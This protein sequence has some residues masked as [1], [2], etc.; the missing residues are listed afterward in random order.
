MRLPTNLQRS[1]A[2]LAT[3]FH[4]LEC[5]SNLVIRIN[6]SQATIWLDDWVRTY[7][8]LTTKLGSN[9]RRWVE[10]DYASL[11]RCHS[12]EHTKI[13]P[14]LAPLATVA[15]CIQSD[16]KIGDASLIR[17]LSSMLPF[18]LTSSNAKLVWPP[19]PLRRRDSR[20]VYGPLIN[21]NVASK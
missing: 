12:I 13:V 17:N 14:M 19:G 3:W 2:L 10:A 16:H 6:D 9:W 11:N 5:N 7:N 15:F 4:L 1:L 21:W 8:Y 20:H 18:L